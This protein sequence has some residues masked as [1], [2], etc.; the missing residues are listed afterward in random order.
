MIRTAPHMY[1]CG[2]LGE[3]HKAPLATRTNRAPKTYV[4]W[5]IWTLLR[6]L[7]QGCSLGWPTSTSCSS[8]LSTVLWLTSCAAEV[9]KTGRPH[10]RSY[11]EG[12]SRLLR[13][14]KTESCGQVQCQARPD[15]TAAKRKER[16]WL[17]RE[18]ARSPIILGATRM[19]SNPTGAE[20][21]WIRSRPSHQIAAGLSSQ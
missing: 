13:S 6:V 19:A 5:E 20:C 16:V 9:P 15:W 10:G 4:F 8:Q 14:S 7:T 11:V 1:T 12:V 17:R 2:G 18:S 3:Q 21:G